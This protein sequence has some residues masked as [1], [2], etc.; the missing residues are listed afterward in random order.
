VSEGMK[1]SPEWLPKGD[2]CARCE[3]ESSTQRSD[4]AAPRGKHYVWMKASDKETSRVK[5]RR[6]GMSTANKH[7]GESESLT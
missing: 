3:S 2:E 6:E 7:E 5:A 4:A 1:Y